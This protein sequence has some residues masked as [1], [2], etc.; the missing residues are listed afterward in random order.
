MFASE[1]GTELDA[2][3]VRSGFRRI[4]KEAGLVA[5]DRTSRGLRHGFASLL[6]DGGL[7]IEQISR[8]VGR[9]GTAVTETIYG[10]GSTLTVDG[11]T[12]I[13]RILPTRIA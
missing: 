10:T 12:A 8:L 1:V 9:G 4:A 7:P 2:A 5:K 6:S 11:A 13:D 3:N